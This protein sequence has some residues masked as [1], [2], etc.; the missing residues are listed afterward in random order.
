[1]TGSQISYLWSNPHAAEG[2]NSGVSLHSHTSQSKE[3]L[4]FLANLGNR[5]H[6]IRKLL[7]FCERAPPSGTD[8]GSITPPL[9]GRRP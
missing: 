8:S 9:T 5:S 2:F 7:R 3:T 1:M 4:D 6:L